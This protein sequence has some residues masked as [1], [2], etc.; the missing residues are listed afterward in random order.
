MKSCLTSEQC[1]AVCILSSLTTQ[2]NS[3]IGVKTRERVG[4]NLKRKKE[5]ILAKEWKK[6]EQQQ[7]RAEVSSKGRYFFLY[8]PLQRKLERAETVIVGDILFS[9]LGVAGKRRITRWVN[10]FRVKA[11][12]SRTA[13]ANYAENNCSPFSER[14]KRRA[15][16]EMLWIAG[17]RYLK[18]IKMNFCITLYHSIFI[19]N[20]NLM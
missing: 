4:P 3:R 18:L 17:K 1:S 10:C 6:C 20:W 15:C 19:N 9:P 7:E 13:N 16:C 12:Y 8:R 14:A 11:T 2:H 5:L